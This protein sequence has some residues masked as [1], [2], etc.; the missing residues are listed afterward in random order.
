MGIERALL[1]HLA[2]LAVP[3]VPGLVWLWIFYRTDRYEPEPKR[4]VALT[5]LLGVAAI[6]PAFGGELLVDAIHPYLGTIARAAAATSAHAVSALPLFFACFFVIGPCEELSKFLAVRLF[7]YRNREFDEPLDGIIY[8]A[9]AALGFASLENI[10][11]VIDFH[12]GWSIRWSMLGARAFLALPGHVIFAATWGYAL[13]RRKF[14]PSYLVWPRLLIAAALHGLYDFVL[15]YPPARPLIV[16][17]MAL[18]V[19]VVVR[20]IRILRSES[21]FR[22]A[23]EIEA[24]PG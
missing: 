7:I 5:F 24:E 4:L 20:E 23:S 2:E 19:P 12:H 14:D 8:A 15:M 18:M 13:G 11:Y 6:L 1:I 10:L 9:A 3:I 22:P 17:Y 21:P 16:L